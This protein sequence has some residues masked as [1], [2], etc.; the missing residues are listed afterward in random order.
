MFPGAVYLKI[1]NLAENRLSSIPSEL[2]GMRLVELTVSRNRLSKILFPPQIRSMA[3]LRLLDISHNLLHALTSAEI[4]MSNLQTANLSGNRL[5]SLP[6]ISKW[7]ELLTLT[8][9]EN[10]ISE[11]PHGFVKLP[12]LKNA[13][14]SN[15]NITQLDER[16]ATMENLVAV[17][18]AGNPLREREFLTMST[19]ELKADLQKRSLSMGSLQ[20]E[21]LI[22]PTFHSS[23]G[24]VIDFSSQSLFDS[25]L[26]ALKFDGPAFDLRLHHNS[27][28]AILVSLISPAVISA[29]LRNLNLP[30]NPMETIYLSSMLS[31]PQLK[32]LC[33]TSCNLKSLHGLTSYLSAPI[34][35]T[36]NLSANHLCGT[37]SKLRT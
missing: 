16:I 26:P 6:D 32:E 14:L 4:E 15:N 17:N 25:K 2:L 30:H 27:F 21:K 36:L 12:K 1:V 13:D 9:A 19:D 35:T 11:I 10:M 3:T 31:L 33:L 28:R 34:M 20:E 29:T 7:T 5:R 24:G 22:C 8:A 18:L 23:S 37:L